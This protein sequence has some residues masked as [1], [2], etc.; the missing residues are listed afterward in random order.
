MLIVM[1]RLLAGVF[2]SLLCGVRSDTLS[3]T[4]TLAF[5]FEHETFVAPSTP[6]Y[7]LRDETSSLMCDRRAVPRRIAIA[8]LFAAEVDT[9]EIALDEYSGLA[10]V[11]LFE[12]RAVH[13]FQEA[14]HKPILWPILRQQARFQSYTNIHFH[15][16]LFNGTKNSTWS[17]EIANNDCINKHMQ[18]VASK[19]DIIV[20]GSVDE[21]I[22][23][24]N[25]A[26]L[27]YCAETPSL[28]RNAAMAMPLGLLG[29]RFQTDWHVETMPYS[30]ISPTV[31]AG[32]NASRNYLRILDPPFSN[33]HPIVGGLHAS[34]YCFLPQMIIKE[35]I[36][37]S[38]SN[39]FAIDR[40]C[41][42][43]LEATKQ[44]CYDFHK[45][46]HK[47]GVGNETILPRRLQQQPER[48][49]SW[50]G[51][52]DAREVGVFRNLCNVSK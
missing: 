50:Y 17:V 19:Y 7:A 1:S 9:L 43:G 30:W 25:Y 8:A 21:I 40:L 18:A 3:H 42:E 41:R 29:R 28:P 49:P 32:R 12:N 36:S 31:Y 2:A 38:Y 23:R 45:D 5:L 27:K 24:K 33:S 39:D 11:Y 10:D 6:K 52:V 26:A 15:F 16:C 22:A 13:H 48:F 46:R 35:L 20:V 44:R 34:N 14:A 51:H 47:P 37:S 4:S